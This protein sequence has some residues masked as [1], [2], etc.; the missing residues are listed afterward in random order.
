MDCSI[1]RPA[2]ASR[3]SSMTGAPPLVS[4]GPIATATGIA[5]I[6]YM[7]AIVRPVSWDDWP[8]NATA[9]FRGLRSPEG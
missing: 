5:G 1:T 2:I 9:I 6:A 7:E 4:T 8:D 3:W